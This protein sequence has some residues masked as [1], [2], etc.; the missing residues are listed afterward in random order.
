[1]SLVVDLLIIV[2]MYMLVIL[3]ALF[4]Q[5]KPTEISIQPQHCKNGT[6]RFLLVY[7]M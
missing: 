1:M 3:I 4:I 7:F 5:M 2:R 6:E